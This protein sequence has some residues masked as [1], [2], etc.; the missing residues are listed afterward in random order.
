VEERVECT[1]SLWA[2][3]AFS[4][5]LRYQPPWLWVS[6]PPLE[7]SHPTCSPRSPVSRWRVGLLSLH[8]S[9]YIYLCI[10]V[11]IIYLSIHGSIC[12]YQSSI[13]HSLIYLSIYQS[14]ISQ[15]FIYL[16]IY[17]SNADVSVDKP[18]I[19]GFEFW[20]LKAI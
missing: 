2:A 4:S 19:I 16:S 15:S 1:L 20:F 5:A 14:L 10:Y 6:G 8:N 11:S 17:L 12:I 13:Y 3:A 18:K 7:L 9:Y